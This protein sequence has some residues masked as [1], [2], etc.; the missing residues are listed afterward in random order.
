MRE[1]K[2]ASQGEIRIG[3]YICHCGT[4]IAGKVR[5]S[6]VVE[7]VK[8]LP[9]VVV[10]RD[11]KYMC[12]D[13]GQALIKEDIKKFDLNRV[14][15]A[16]CSPHLHEQTFRKAVL[17][18][19][20]N[21]FLFHMANIREHVSWTTEDPEEA[22]LKAKAVIMGAVYRSKFH[23]PLQPKKEKVNPEVLVVGGGIAGISASLVLANSDK[24]V[25]L[26]EKNPTI[27][28]HMAKFDKTFPTLDCASCIL[29]PKM[30]AV[31]DHPN[32]NLITYAEVKE[33]KGYVGNFKIKILKK[34]RYVD[35]DKCIGCYTCIENCV[36]KEPKFPSE[37][38]EGVAL[39][40]PVYIPFPQAVPLV[41]VIDPGTC[42]EFKTH[43]CPKTCKKACDEIVGR[44]AIDFTQKEKEIEVEVGA[45]IVATGY[46]T[47]DA[48]KISRYGYGKYPWVYTAL[49]VERLLNS[50]GPT[51]G[52][53]ILRDGSIPKKV[54][55]VHCV[56]SRDENYNIY[57]SKVC[58]MYSLKFAHL[59]RERTNAQVY[60][61]Y[62]DMRTPG[63]GYE[64]FYKRLM[65]E[66]TIF[67][68][69][70]VA[71]VTDIFESEEEKEGKLVVVV[72]DTLMGKIRRIPVDM[73]ILSVGIEPTAD[74]EEIRRIFNITCS[75]EGW[76]MERHPKLAPVST[77][78]EGIFIA[79]AA[80]GPKDIPETVAQAE[81]AAAEAMAI[82]DKGYIELEPYIAVINE[83]E[84]SGC[85]ICV[86]ICPYSAIFFDNEKKVA[87]INEA[88]CK[89]CGACV[90][91]CPSKA[92]SQK[93]FDDKQIL[94][95]IKGVLM[96]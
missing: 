75:K 1:K 10:A 31:K 38:D 36:Y 28:G 61:F 70:K 21:P 63:K 12:S 49:E 93:F 46:K 45:I 68:R 87:K 92:I 77:Y 94:A 8:K 65:D 91:T 24:K 73:V 72:E 32:I 69:G 40:K 96:I 90:G 23:E 9:G 79:G 34:P 59:I 55:I 85:R 57:C 39:R 88:L 67:I 71:E 58:C 20:L 42:I 7:F 43:K 82:I 26:V 60:N 41:A 64:E 15:V 84:C 83:E 30:T 6:E 89:G 47:F 78:T 27:G 44:S 5:V 17:E 22:T 81:A 35:E 11:Y 37:F 52:E 3:V 95:E 2:K 29:T 33:V 25:H 50:A 62:I 54:G 86:A 74:A 16:S 56:G 18:G 51:G 66:G 80:Q 19:G 4:N 14:I 13:P 53:V 48:K 76:F